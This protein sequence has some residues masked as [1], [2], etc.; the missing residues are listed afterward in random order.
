MTMA[1][2]PLP[3]PGWHPDPAGRHELR[4]WDGSQWSEHVADQGKVGTDDLSNPVPTTAATTTATTT[5]TPEPVTET[6]PATESAPL[7]APPPSVLAAADGIVT[8]AAAAPIGTPGGAPGAPPRMM[9]S[10]GGLA[11]SLTVI[12]WVT[13]AVSAFTAVAFFN[14]AIVATDMIDFDFSRGLSEAFDLQ[15]RADDADSLVGVAFFLTLTVTLTIGVL[16][17]IWM[18]RV[19]KNRDL[20]GRTDAK[21]GPGW[22]I[23]GWFI[24]LASLVIPVL[25][26]QELWRGSDPSQPRA[27][28]LWRQAKGSALVG[29]WW[30]AY[31]VMT[32]RFVSG[33][34]ATTESELRRLRAT[35][36]VAGFGSLAAVAAAILLIFVVRRITRR[37]EALFAGSPVVAD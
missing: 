4:Y 13:V 6:T 21:W 37:Q 12:L 5:D 16:L 8:P 33:G 14:R 10:I 19:A 23:G 29:W 22:T 7:G 26:M 34:D 30:V 35:D 1:G 20:A 28:N 9:R 24:P 25:V 3:P 11:A 15:Q 27:G 18:W 31:L 32:L 36:A 17:L 2:P